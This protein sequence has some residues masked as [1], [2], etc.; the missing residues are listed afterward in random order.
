MFFLLLVLTIFFY[1]DSIHSMETQIVVQ[2]KAFDFDK[3]P[4]E[5]QREVDI[6]YLYS[7]SSLK[8]L[9]TIVPTICLVSKDT[10][11]D[12]QEYLATDLLSVMNFYSNKFPLIFRR[13]IICA[14]PTQLKKSY[15]Q[16]GDSFI[17]SLLK[18]N[19][20]EAQKLLKDSA[21]VNISYRY[22]IDRYTDDDGAITTICHTPF[23]A[24]ICDESRLRLD[25]DKKLKIIH[26]LLQNSANP[27]IIVRD[28]WGV[29]YLLD[30]IIYEKPTLA[31]L[32]IQ[33]KANPYIQGDYRNSVYDKITKGSLSY[34]TIKDIES[35][36]APEYIKPTKKIILKKH[37]DSLYNNN[38]LDDNTFLQKF[39][40]FDLCAK[41]VEGFT[42]LHK[43]TQWWSSKIYEDP[44]VNKLVAK[45]CEIFLKQKDVLFLIN[46]QT[47]YG[48]TA[49]ACLCANIGGKPLI[50]SASQCIKLLLRYKA[51]PTIGEFEDGH[52]CFDF[53]R[54]SPELLEILENEQAESQ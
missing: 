1:C 20:D 54:N 2:D 7:A 42:F 11:N 34:L 21:D 35:L 53:A 18:S 3:L 50:E 13:N 48:H 47:I 12:I 19:F 33:Y 14:F 27:N 52:N 36:I 45:K 29:D 40:R 43:L 28:S 49:L 39:E 4:K 31:K 15:L 51:D 16:K 9:R 26:F 24:Y 25:K 17:N 22:S 10:F 32:L 44:E 37:I 41:N 6:K 30:K 23:L 38:T 46:A 5:L 8:E